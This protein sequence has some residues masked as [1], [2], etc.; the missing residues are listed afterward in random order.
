MPKKPVEY[1]SGTVIGHYMLIRKLSKE[2]AN[3]KR[4]LYL[5]KCLMCGKLYKRTVESIKRSK[6]KMCISCSNKLKWTKHGL[7]NNPLYFVFKNMHDRCE[8]SKNIKYND[9]GGRGIKVCKEWEDTEDGLKSFINWSNSNG[10]KNGLQIDRIDNDKGYSSDNCRWVTV[11]QNNFN[12]RNTKGYRFHQ[13]KWE[14]YIT[15]NK[16][17][18]HLGRFSTEEEALD[19]RK[20]AELKYFGEYSPSHRE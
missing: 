15:V 20:V 9:Y 1:E 16:K 13:G 17:T 19:A 4:G 2:E 10:Y 6:A 12:R 7:S 14:A 8:K 5:C 18:I 3:G 11:S